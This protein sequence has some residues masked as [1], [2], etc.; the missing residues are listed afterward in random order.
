MKKQYNKVEIEV[1]SLMAK[2]VITASEQ[3]Y[4]YDPDG[5]FENNNNDLWQWN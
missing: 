1:I 4:N 3:S 2:D 5:L